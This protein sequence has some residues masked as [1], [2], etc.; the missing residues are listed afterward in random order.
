M[1]SRW[2]YWLA[3][4]AALA[5][6]AGAGMH[7]FDWNWLRAPIAKHVERATGRTFAIRGNFDVRLSRHPRL[8]A[9]GLVIGNAPWAR[10]PGMAEIGRVE[11]TVDV[12]ALWRGRVVLPEVSLSEARIL[13]EK[14]SDGAANWEFGAQGGDAKRGLPS[15][16]TL[17]L[18]RARFVFR[19]PAIKTDIA[20]EVSTIPADQKNAGMWKITGRGR[21]KGMPTTLDGV[22]GSV[23]T[24]AS[25]RP[26]P[27]PV[28]LR[29]VLGTT[30][31]RINGVLADPLHLN[32]ENLNFELEGADMAQ[33]FPLLGMPLPPTPPYKLSGHL[34]H[35][36]HVWTFR[37]FAGRVG[38][39]DLAG[40]FSV[41]LGRKPRFITANLV[42][43]NLDIH[44]LGGF[45]GAE[46]G[47]ARASPTPP[48]PGRVLPHEPFSLEKLR[49]ANADVQFRGEHVL[50]GKLPLEKIT[51]TLKLRDGAITLEPLNFGVAGG[52]LVSQIRMDARQSVIK[53]RA[54]ISVRQVRLEKLFPGFRL[55]RANAGTLTGRAK[56]DTTGNSVAK[57]LA[58]ADG[59]AALMMEG[60]SI[61]ELLV[62][63]INLDVANA[64]PVLLTGDKQLPVRCMAAH[65]NGKDGDFKVKTLVLDTGK[66]VVTGS[67]GINFADESLDLSLVSKSKGFSLV[68]LRGPINITGTFKDPKTGPD[69]KNAAGRGAAAIA[70]GWATGGLGALLP[71]ID[72]GG[73]QDSDCAALIQEATESVPRQTRQKAKTGQQGG[74]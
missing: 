19:D 37:K 72:L 10:E 70:L 58:A 40:D 39:S 35:S 71:L 8:T 66:A 63:L 48:P 46:R 21:V 34:N 57:M 6:L 15:I 26:L 53:T 55:G 25:A 29:A 20:T 42:S 56:I 28:N 67:G 27:Y 54:D 74:R 2:K 4:F 5:L 41:D 38:N 62:R 61:S 49:V 18:D 13:L 11:F 17:T 12:L 32:G 9:E 30:R 43:R 64:I 50:T 31:A 33:L 3:G 47:D 24:L 22:V 16:G 52:N 23:L 51:A 59:D 1:T 44:D 36:G 73:A 69:L 68:A 65:L 60:G 45:I 14:N 7:F